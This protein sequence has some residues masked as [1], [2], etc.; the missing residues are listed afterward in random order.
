M[1]DI[2]PIARFV[3]GLLHEVEIDAESKVAKKLI[4]EYYRNNILSNAAN[5][6]GIKM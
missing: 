3:V 4:A 1:F 6:L 2:A 5:K